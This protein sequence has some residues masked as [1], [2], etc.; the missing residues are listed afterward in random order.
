MSNYVIGA[1]ICGI[2][3]VLIINSKDETHSGWDD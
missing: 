1:I 2:V 3:L